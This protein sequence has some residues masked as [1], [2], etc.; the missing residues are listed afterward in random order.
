MLAVLNFAFLA[1]SLLEPRALI[2]GRTFFQPLFIV[3]AAVAPRF[4]HGVALYE[5]C[6]SN[7]CFPTRPQIWLVL[8]VWNGCLTGPKLY[9]YSSLCISVRFSISLNIYVF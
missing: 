2:V 6:M 3:S 5:G 9:L 8:P 1:C 4:Q 7:A